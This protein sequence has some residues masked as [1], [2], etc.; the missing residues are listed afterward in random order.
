MTLTHGYYKTSIFHNSHEANTSALPVETVI[1]STWVI[2]IFE[3]SYLCR[4]AYSVT[5]C[6]QSMVPIHPYQHIHFDPLA[7]TCTNDP[8]R[9]K[10]ECCTLC[11][12]KR[13]LIDSPLDSYPCIPVSALVQILRNRPYT[14]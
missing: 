1:E 9:M 7:L 13:W 2:K 12:Q 6:E 14:L 4:K 5:D 3:F 11:T 10:G 8:L